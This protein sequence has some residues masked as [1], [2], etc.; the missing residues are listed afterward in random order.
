MAVNLMTIVQSLKSNLILEDKI[1]EIRESMRKKNEFFIYTTMWVAAII[2]LM[3]LLVQ[4]LG[5]ARIVNY[6]GIVRGATQK[7]I[8]EEMNDDQDDALIAR[9]DGIIENL[10]TGKGEF[11]LHRNGNKKYQNELSILKNLWEDM[12]EEI[13]RVRK[14]Q[15]STDNLYELSQEHFA[16]ADQMVLLAEESSEQK[17]HRFIGIYAGVLAFLIGSFTVG[18]RRNQ[19]ALEESIYTDSL[20]GLLNREGFKAEAVSLLRQYPDNQYCLVEF[21]IDDFKF[22][23]NSYGY[24]QGDKLLCALADSIQFKYHKDQLC[25]RIA[26][27]DF[28]ILAKKTT[29]LVD[30][31]RRL[32]KDTLQQEALLNLSE[33][34]TYTFGAYEIPEGYGRI[35]SVMDKA[36]IAHKNAK[37]LG[38]SMTVWYDETFLE[39][40]NWENQLTKRFKRALGHAE[41]KMYLQSKYSLNDLKIQSAEALVRWE[42]PG[43]G[44]V[45]PDDFI[46]LFERNGD[47]AEIDFYILEKACEF[48]RNHLDTCGREF[49]VSVN[50]SR[51]TIYQ[52]RCYSTIME[53]VDRYQIPHHC[54]ELEITESAFNGISE[55]IIQKITNLQEMGFIISMDDFGSGYSSLNLLDK[56]PIQ[57]LK[58]D[59]EF[60][61]EYGIGEKAKNVI[62]CV[63]EL[64]HTLDIEVVCEGVEKQEHVDFLK[65]IGC[66]YGQGYFFTK[67]IPQEEFKLKYENFY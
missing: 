63:T 57:T 20:T 64:A 59:R 33:F 43:H 67:P 29:D 38:K 48:I 16:I 32:L 53:I 28:M 45:C 60:L 27:D 47:I 26:S 39:K 46:P 23:N 18:N 49:S 3:V 4:N 12:K 51:V 58:L 36:N 17:L 11:N 30:D 54:I 44:I 19:K 10:Q 61:R 31:M 50:F 41:F 5:D 22:L 55:V 15:V 7:L 8:K 65:N 2:I 35:Q 62:S 25:A 52:Q 56:L 6:S 37:T 13:Y 14:K 9:L 66:D 1:M 34:I 21:D 42:I 24:E 40:L